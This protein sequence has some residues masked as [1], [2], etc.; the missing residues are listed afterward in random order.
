ML[1]LVGYFAV[2]TDICML[3][4]IF[5]IFLAVLSYI[6]IFSLGIY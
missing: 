2:M 1:I 4:R 5:F 6:W 3:I